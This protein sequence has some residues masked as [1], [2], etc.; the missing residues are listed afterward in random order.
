MLIQLFSH[1]E[2]EIVRVINVKQMLLDTV[3]AQV[4]ELIASGL[5]FH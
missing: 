3:E 1:L 4:K 2:S 5:Y